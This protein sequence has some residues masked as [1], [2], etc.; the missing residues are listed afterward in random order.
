[1]KTKITLLTLCVCTSISCATLKKSSYV[2]QWIFNPQKDLL[3]LHYDHA[4]DKDDGHSAAADRTILQ[5]LYGK[6]WIT[7]HVV[8]VSGAYGKNA[9]DFNP[10]SDAVMD[11]AWND[12]GGWLAAHTSHDNVIS[13]LT[14]RWSKTLQAGGDIWIKEGGQSDITAL[15][16]RN[17]IRQ[18]PEVDTTSRIHTVQHSNWNEDQTAE[19]ALAYTRRH[20]HYTLIDDANAYLNIPRGNEAFVTSAT[21]HSELGVV[22]KAAFAYYNPKERLDFS[23]TG[24]LLY[25]LGL[26]KLNFDG[27]REKFLDTTDTNMEK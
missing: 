19:N 21:N 4:P 17:I 14:K 6:E 26:G 13:E 24:E 9:N 22:W 16:V 1:M 15:V 25:I 11:A 3:S 7:K 10:N 27:F 18:M 5:T 2:K 20:T 12:C 23:D 8:A